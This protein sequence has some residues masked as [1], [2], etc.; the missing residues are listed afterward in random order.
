MIRALI[1]G[2]KSQTRRVLKPQ[3]DYVFRS[4]VDGSVD[5]MQRI[6][7]KTVTGAEIRVTVSFPYTPGDR[8]YVREAFAISGIGW[9]KKPAD[10]KGGKVHYRADPDHGWHDYW[11]SWRPSIHMPR[12]ASRLTLIVTDVRVQRLQDI[13]E[14]DAVAEGVTPINETNE[15]RWEHYSPHGVSF[16]D[17]WS[18]LH[19]PD[20]WA[21]NPWVVALTFDVHRCNIDQMP[22]DT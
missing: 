9:G 10:A 16:R 5:S 14:A 19:G 1:D 6:I 3:P 11:G 4:V 22:E 7:G 17:L 18:S 12:W 13:S 2:R 20:A 8:I 21:A 15:L